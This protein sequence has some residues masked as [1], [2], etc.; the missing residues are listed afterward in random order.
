MARGISLA[1]AVSDLRNELGQTPS[2]VVGVNAWSR[3][4]SVI[5]RVQEQLAAEYAWPFLRIRH[6]NPVQAGLRYYDLPDNLPFERLEKLSYKYGGDWHTVEYGIDTDLY[7]IQDSDADQRSDP[8]ERWC[9]YNDGPAKGGQIEVWPVPQTNG[10]LYVDDPLAPFEPGRPINGDGLLRFSG[11]RTV[12]RLVS[13]DDQLE[14]DDRL[15][16]LTAAAELLAEQN[17]QNAQIVA[18]R[19]LARS[20]TL[21]GRQQKTPSFSFKR[22]RLSGSSPRHG[23]IKVISQV[24]N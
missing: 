13:E 14:L 12:S 11:T 4:A 16:V 10:A 2:S 20:H 22:S 18:Q 1:R 24:T 6:I 7:D 23:G 5:D 15:V 8:I 3:H 9:P 19:A 17:K 21:I